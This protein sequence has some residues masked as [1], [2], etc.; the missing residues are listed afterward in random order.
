MKKILLLTF[1][2]GMLLYG[3]CLAAPGE[4]ETYYDKNINLHCMM[5]MITSATVLT[6]G[7]KAWASDPRENE[8][9]G[10]GNYVYLKAGSFTKHKAH[11]TFE[12]VVEPLWNNGTLGETDP[13][14]NCR[15]TTHYRRAP[16]AYCTPV[17]GDLVNG[18]D[19]VVFT[20]PGA[21]VRNHFNEC[22]LQKRSTIP[23]GCMGCDWSP[24]GR[25]RGTADYE[26][27]CQLRNGKWCK[28]G[29]TLNMGHRCTVEIND[30][31]KK[32][33]IA[34]CEKGEIL[35]TLGLGPGGTVELDGQ[36]NVDLHYTTK[37]DPKYSY[38]LTGKCLNGS[39]IW[40]K[41]KNT[42]Y[43]SYECHSK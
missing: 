14:W 35:Y 40:L 6:K 36:D 21:K 39:G 33:V 42:P 34:N 13:S 41:Q 31:Q 3:L 15:V 19:N 37:R 11:A 1:A 2:A 10:K 38:N 25:P 8:L 17:E 4:G 23:Q 7:D 43:V 24:T 5:C 9:G 28:P 29:N 12:I 26:N 22:Y 30:T 27:R 32:R 18:R 20:C 16:I